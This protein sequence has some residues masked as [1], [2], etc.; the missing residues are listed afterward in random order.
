MT[1]K[2]I[3]ILVIYAGGMLA[4]GAVLSKRNKTAV[5]MFAVN[6]QSPWWLAG[7]SAFMSA[8]SS[9]TFVVWGGIAF[10]YGVVAISI[11]LCLGIASLLVGKFLAGVWAGLGI[12]S[13]SEFVEIR[14]GKQAVLFYT[15]AGMIFKIVAMAV[16][17]YSFS[18]LLSALIDVPEGYFFRNDTSGKLSITYACVI[19]GI[20]ML[21]YAV[22]GGL[23]AVLIIDAVQFIVLT[24]SVLFVVP[25]AFNYIG[26]VDEFFKRA[27][28]GFL[29]PVSGGFS[30]YF[31]MGWVVVH[32]FKLGGEWVFIQRFLAVKDKSSAKKSTYFLGVLFLVLPIFWML[33]PMVYRIVDPSAN[34]EFSYFLMC[35]AVLPA[36]MIGLLVAA[37]FSATAS[38]IDGEVNVY[39][40]ALTRDLYL[41]Y[42]NPHATPKSEVLAG[43]IFSMLIGAVIII[44][45][46]LIPK[47]GGAESVILTITGLLAVSM[48]LPPVW[49]LF[50]GKIR[51]DAVWYCS[52][53]T[54][55]AAIL[56]KFFVPSEPTSPFWITVNNNLQLIEVL[57]GICVPCLVLLIMELRETEVH[58]GFLHLR[59]MEKQAI[60]N[61]A[62]IEASIFPGK[63]LALSICTLGVLMILMA[64]FAETSQILMTI[65]GLVFLMLSGIILFGIKKAEGNAK[66]LVENI[67]TQESYK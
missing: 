17:L 12:K 58:P 45:A 61:P 62:A 59:Q 34:P 8:F 39:A 20:L 52:G 54:L 6:R 50:F 1:F 23:W 42:L 11:L 4:I 53:T 38:S 67:K 15:W 9:G 33:P 55:L 13:I 10:K 40:G 41:R 56:I 35:T 57:T 26:G 66:L 19:S 32:F 44:I 7:L 63:I 51:Q 27:P 3:L 2:D 28:E 22:S 64:L 46:A 60:G 24:A 30:Y 37:M 16:A 14:F 43:R 29:S 31:L 25:L 18:T 21:S 48:V 47:L 36:G 65:F 49:G 5:D